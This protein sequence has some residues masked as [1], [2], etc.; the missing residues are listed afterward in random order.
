MSTSVF[1]QGTLLLGVPA[2]AALFGWL[3]GRLIRGGRPR[4]EVEHPRIAMSAAYLRDAHNNRVSNL[5]R[6]RCAFEA[7]YFCLC[8]VADARG[9]EMEGRAHPNDEILRVGLTALGASSEDS[10][11]AEKLA[12]WA[13][14]TTPA[15]PDISLRDA[16]RL[17][18]RMYDDTV[19]LL[20]SR[21]FDARKR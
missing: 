8:E 14:D 10:G 3:I 21:G 17:A 4:I 5:T 20:R 7:L 13:A 15:L 18:V 19:K 16:C 9:V 2:A 11:N 1:E 12:K 6:Y